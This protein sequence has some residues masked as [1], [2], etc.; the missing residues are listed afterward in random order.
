VRVV[1]GVA[2][3]S[4]A[5]KAPEFFA[6]PTAPSF[7]L[8]T[9]SHP[10]VHP[11]FFTCMA[12]FVR[13]IVRTAAHSSVRRKI[14]VPRIDCSGHLMD[15]MTLPRLVLEILQGVT[16]SDEI[17]FRIGAGWSEGGSFL[18]LLLLPFLRLVR[19]VSPLSAGSSFLGF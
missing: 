1:V 9:L 3:V 15:G 12:P 19:L 13:E 17:G 10:L 18:L 5:V 14:L 16:S 2:V 4:S 8:V 7:T 11:L 6:L